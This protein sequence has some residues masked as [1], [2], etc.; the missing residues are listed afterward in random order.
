M[1]SH[2]TLG[3]ADIARARE[4]YDAIFEPLGIDLKFGGDDHAGYGP[5]G[6]PAPM[7]WLL[8][9][10]NDQPATA[11]NGTHLAFLA[12][13]RG[14]VDKFHRL[15]LSHGATDEGAPGLRPHYHEHYYG[16][17]IRDADGNKLQACCHN[18]E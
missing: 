2:A 4:L 18:P 11:G 10:F 17:Y 16:A 15:A 13:N 1:Y 6:Q 5:A 7:F 14:A 8:L 3:V 9:P 12:P